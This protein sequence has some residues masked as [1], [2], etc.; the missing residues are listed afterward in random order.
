MQND[1]SIAIEKEKKGDRR[2]KSETHLVFKY[3]NAI[4]YRWGRRKYKRLRTRKRFFN[5]MKRIKAKY[6]DLFIFWKLAGV[7][8]RTV[9]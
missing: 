1:C 8:V 6:P 9:Q 3:F 5:W 2:R 4:P 7:G